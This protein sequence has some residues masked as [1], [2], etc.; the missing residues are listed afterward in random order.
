MKAFLLIG[1]LSVTT[2][3][4][5]AVVKSYDVDQACTLYRVTTEKRGAKI[6]MNT[7]ESVVFAKGV[8]GLTLQNMEINFDYREVKV[9]ITINVIMGANRP[10]LSEKSTISPE[11]AEFT[12]LINHLNRKLS[13]LEKVCLST[14]N[15]IIYAKQFENN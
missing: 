2:S 15:Q 12:T 10:L 9:Q 3:A 5:S 7:L 11:D 4:F 6:K 1:L 8:Y 13:S 14:N